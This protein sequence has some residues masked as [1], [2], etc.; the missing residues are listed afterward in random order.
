[1]SK[2]NKISREKWNQLKRVADMYEVVG[3]QF[4][5]SVTY[6]EVKDKKIKKGLDLE[7]GISV[8]LQ[9]SIKDIVKGLANNSS[10]PI[11]NQAIDNATKNRQ[12]NQDYLDVFF[13][14]FE[15]ASAGKI[16]LACFIAELKN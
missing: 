15:K 13:D 16:K 10:N 8:Q 12:G 1:M 4:G 7:G 11:F 3:Y 2:F 5:K 14:E 9:I 6:N